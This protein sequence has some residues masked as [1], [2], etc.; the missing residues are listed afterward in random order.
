MLLSSPIMLRKWSCLGLCQWFHCCT[1]PKLVK[2]Q[3]S[4][5]WLVS[6]RWIYFCLKLSQSMRTVARSCSVF[7]LSDFRFQTEKQKRTTTF[8]NKAMQQNKREMGVA[9]PPRHSLSKSKEDPISQRQHKVVC[10]ADRP[11]YILY[12]CAIRFKYETFYQTYNMQI[13]PYLLL[14]TIP[15]IGCLIFGNAVIMRI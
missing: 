5:R 15:A 12:Y 13:V 10:L 14:L 11:L 2:N 8:G 4:I 1:M 3:V 6:H 7:H 9:K